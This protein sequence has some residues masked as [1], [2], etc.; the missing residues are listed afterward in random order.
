MSRVTGE[1]T[2]LPSTRGGSESTERE[3]KEKRKRGRV[4]ERKRLGEEGMR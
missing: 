3:R 2:P 4:G 1:G